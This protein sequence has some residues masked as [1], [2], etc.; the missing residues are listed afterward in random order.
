MKMNEPRRQ[1]AERQNTQ[2]G[3]KSD[4]QAYSSFERENLP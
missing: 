4:S 2:P 1:K 3:V